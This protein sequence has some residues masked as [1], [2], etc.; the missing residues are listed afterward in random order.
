MPREA[1]IIPVEQ[2][3]SQKS[4]VTSL[5]V[6]QVKVEDDKQLEFDFDYDTYGGGTEDFGKSTK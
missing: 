1:I 2:E 3:I 6:K 4:R 5:K